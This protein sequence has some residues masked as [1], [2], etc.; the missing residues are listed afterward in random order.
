TPVPDADRA[1]RLDGWKQ[2]A[3]YLQRGVR[4]VRRWEREEGLPVHRHVHRVL[5]SV[6]A[7]KSEIDLW[8]RADRALAVVRESPNALAEAAS[9]SQS[10]AVLPFTNLSTDPDNA[11][12]ADGLTDE[13]T[14]DLS[15]V[16]A[17]RVTSRTSAMTFKGTAKDCKT[18]AREL[19]VR[20]VLEGSVRRAGRRLRI[21]AQLVDASTDHH[22]W[23]DKY[24]GDVEDVFAFQER[25]ARVIVDA[26]KLDLS[27]DED[28]RLG[29]HPI[30]SL[31]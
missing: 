20:Y 13:I 22:L 4:T 11:Y 15:K 9:R 14:A 25:L 21:T 8:Q 31:P 30:G 24:D 5:G 27:A 3:V 7:F 26:L 6:Y 10:I 23:A 28:R 12:F 29:E 18:I 16:R 19:G 1:D 17:L 2:I